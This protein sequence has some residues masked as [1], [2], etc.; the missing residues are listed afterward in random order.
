MELSEEQEEENM[1]SIVE[2]LNLNFQDAKSPEEVIKENMNSF[3]DYLRE[4]E[5]NDQLTL[6][7][8]NSSL[9]L[10][11]PGDLAIIRPLPKHSFHRR[12]QSDN[13]PA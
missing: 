6:D 1:V 9:K 7:R 12:S 5:S 11:K 2:E 8:Q 13:L 3:L 4:E 10:L